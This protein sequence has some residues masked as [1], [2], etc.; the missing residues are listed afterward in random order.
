MDVVV[1][2]EVFLVLVLV[3]FFSVLFGFAFDLWVY[4][5]FDL[6]Y[7]GCVDATFW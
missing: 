6:W 7:G 2:F 3:I 1:D 4:L 5:V